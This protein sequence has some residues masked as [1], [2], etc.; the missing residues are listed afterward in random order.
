LDPCESRD[1]TLAIFLC[2]GKVCATT[3]QSSSFS[4]FKTTN[5]T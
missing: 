1:Y 5:T 3:V 2:G 4:L